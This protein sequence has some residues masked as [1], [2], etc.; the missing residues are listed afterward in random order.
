[1]EQQQ[2]DV[3]IDGDRVKV[4]TIG[5]TSVSELEAADAALNV[6]LH[7]KAGRRLVGIT[8]LKRNWVSEG[9]GPSRL[10]VSSSSFANAVITTEMYGR[11][12]AGVDHVEIEGPF[13]ASTPGNDVSRQRILVCHPG[14]SSDSRGAGGGDEA[15]ARQIL[16]TLARRAFRRPLTSGDVRDLTQFYAAGRSAGGFEE[17]IRRGLESILTDPDF[18]FRIEG[19]PPNVPPG[20]SYRLG[21]LD[22]ASRLSFFLWS[23]IPDDE[24]LNV[25]VR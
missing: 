14:A 2:L 11:V 1:D 20:A 22:L 5:G 24:L 6:R 18:L 15:C 19:D 17:G 8:F 4:L 25:A 23:S 3:R 12:D 9:I 13:G 7:V 10:P 21:G 16:T